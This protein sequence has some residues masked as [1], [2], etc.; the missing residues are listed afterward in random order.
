MIRARSAWATRTLSNSGRKRGGAGVAGSGSGAPGT[1]E[2]LGA[3]LVTEAAQARAQAVD[4]RAHAG[5]ARPRADVGDGGRSEG[6]EVAQEDLVGRAVALGARGP[7]TPRPWSASAARRGVEQRPARRDLDE[8]HEEGGRVREAR[9][10]A[11][12]SQSSAS[13]ALSS[14]TRPR[15]CSSS[16]RARASSASRSTPSTWRRAPRPPASR[17]GCST[18]R[19][20]GSRGQLDRCSVQRMSHPRTAARSSISAA[21]SAARKSSSATTGRRS[22]ACG[23]WVDIPT[24]CSMAASA[25]SGARRSSS[26]RSRRARFSARV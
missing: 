5:Q 22:P 2:Q 19:R 15:R 26:W 9:R 16:V 7:A 12:G 14:A 8:P 24:R 23:T 13:S 25:E 1:S 21:S 18:G 10:V 11:A 17:T 6:G 3:A 4:H 20:A